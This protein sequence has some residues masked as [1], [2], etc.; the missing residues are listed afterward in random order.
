MDQL[1]RSNSITAAEATAMKTAMD[2]KNAKALKTFATT[3]DKGA[4][5]A[6]S[7]IDANRMTLLA[8]ILK[9]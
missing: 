6:K 9:K 3:L 5:T 8:E 7:P 1:A 4:K 2:K